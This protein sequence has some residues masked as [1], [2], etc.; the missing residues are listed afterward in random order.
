MVGQQLQDRGVL[1]GRGRKINGKR[2]RCRDRRMGGGATH[3]Y[4]RPID[5]IGGPYFAVSGKANS[6]G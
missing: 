2:G 4:F 3:F 5:W 1:A 6:Y